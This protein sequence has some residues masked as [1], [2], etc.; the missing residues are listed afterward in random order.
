MRR[1]THRCVKI[2]G[3]LLLLG[4]TGCGN[5]PREFTNRTSL[6]Q[7]FLYTQW[8]AAQQIIAT[9]PLLLNPQQNGAKLFSAPTNRAFT[10]QPDGLIVQDLPDVA[11]SQ[12]TSITGQPASDPTGVLL[13]PP[14]CDVRFTPAYSLLGTGVYY[15]RSTNAHL[16]RLSFD[17]RYEFENQ[18]LFRLA[19]NVDER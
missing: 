3:L 15:A 10:I 7:Q 4:F 13:C 18:I 9:T 6:S 1:F 5:A 17:L 19:Y 14:G 2:F 11:A 12:M 8:N 16:D